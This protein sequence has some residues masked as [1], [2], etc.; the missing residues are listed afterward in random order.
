MTSLEEHTGRP[1]VEP[2]LR[3]WID[4]EEPQTALVWRR[5]LPVRSCDG[6]SL[7][8]PHK[9]VDAFLD[10]APPHLSEVLETDTTM[11]VAW[12]LK[13]V[14]AVTGVANGLREGTPI[15]LVLDA[16]GELDADSENEGRWSLG[17]LAQLDG[18]DKDR[19]VRN[20]YG[21]TVV[22]DSRLG[23]LKDGMLSDPE[24]AA[25]AA[26]DDGAEWKA[27]PFRVRE[28]AD[29][30]RLDEPGWKEVHR[31]PL[32]FS[33]DEEETR[34]L[35][36]EEREAAAGSE[37]ARALART[38]QTL[39]AHREAVEARVREVGRALGLSGAYLDMLTIA[40]RLHDEG[41]RAEHWQ[42]A[43]NAPKGDIYAKTRGPV[44]HKVLDG[45]RHELGSLPYLEQDAA[46]QALPPDLQDLALHL[47]AAHHG[48]ARPLIST[49]GGQDAPPSLLAERARAVALRFARL[50]RRWG[51][52]GLAWWEAVLR[53]ADQQASRANDD[54]AGDGETPAAPRAA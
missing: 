7:P 36:V 40:A 31:F 22:V 14:K 52:W 29:R 51:P 5:W 28:T 42:R 49:E 12:L 37:T 54:A 4:E 30:F 11:A 23:G 45:Y 26:M 6:R 33:A 17:R 25:A 43:F 48:G 9:E 35:V 1:E 10:A 38:A 15:L 47:V 27:R 18:K 3:G 32:D 34:W 2:W 50:Q 21:R 39:R 24:G 53:A 16:K 20:L 41:K 46:F 44:S 13:R 19:F 8:V